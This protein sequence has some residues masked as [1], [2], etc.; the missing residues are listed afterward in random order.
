[1]HGY[2]AIG[3]VLTVAAIAIDLAILGD[4]VASLRGTTALLV[5]QA[6]L[7]VLVP[8]SILLFIGA[9]RSTGRIHKIIGY[10]FSAFDALLGIS[11]CVAIVLIASGQ[12]NEPAS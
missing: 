11:A 1:M 9:K 8:A 2:S 10:A 7:L 4:S 5:G 6:V 3:Y 12:A